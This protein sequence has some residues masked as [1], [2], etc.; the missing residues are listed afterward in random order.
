MNVPVFCPDSFVVQSV[1]SVLTHESEKYNIHS[2]KGLNQLCDLGIHLCVK[3]VKS[4]RGSYFQAKLVGVCLASGYYKAHQDN[5]CEK[6]RV[7]DLIDILGHLGTHFEKEINLYCGQQ[8]PENIMRIYL[9]RGFEDGIRLG[10]RICMKQ[11]RP[12]SDSKDIIQAIQVDF[13]E[14][15]RQKSPMR[16]IKQPPKRCMRTQKREKVRE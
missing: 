8:T 11:R 10:K 5:I 9:I 12:L 7:H 13:R 16:I 1:F 3:K 15:Q 2:L 6:G 4:L 14:K